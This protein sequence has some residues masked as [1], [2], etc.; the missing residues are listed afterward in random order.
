MPRIYAHILYTMCSQAMERVK[1][2]RISHPSLFQQQQTYR[3][4]RRFDS[5]ASDRSNECTMHANGKI[6]T[7]RASK[8]VSELCADVKNQKWGVEKKKKKK[9][10]EDVERAR[11]CSPLI[12]LTMK[13]DN[14]SLGLRRYTY[15]Q[16][17]IR[18]SQYK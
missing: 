17:R 4:T 11:P 9:K 3:I 15:T 10:E 14:T 16:K 7:E 6:Q 1:R 13:I 2:R 12:C 5:L 18:T 8:R